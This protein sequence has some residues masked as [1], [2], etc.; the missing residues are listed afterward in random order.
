[1]HHNALLTTSLS[2]TSLLHSD[3]YLSNHHDS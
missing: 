2:L 3:Q 1:M